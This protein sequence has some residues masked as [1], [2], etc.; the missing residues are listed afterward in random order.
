M[1]N[2]LINS[3]LTE[4]KSTLF[5]KSECRYGT[6]RKGIFLVSLFV[7][8]KLI[9]KLDEY[10]INNLIGK[11]MKKSD[12]LFELI[13]NMSMSEKRYFKLF[14]ARTHSEKTLNY[15]VLFDILDRL[16]NYE[17]SKVIRFLKREKI[18]A[19]YLAADKNYLYRMILK[20]LR[21]FHAG[22]SA[23]LRVKEYLEYLEILYHKGLYH[24][25]NKLLQKAKKTAQTF[26]LY[27]LLIEILNW[28]RLFANLNS[29]RKVVTN[30]SIAINENLKL[31]KNINAYNELYHEM[32]LLRLELNKAR[33]QKKLELLEN[34]IQH[35]L[36]ASKEMALSNIAKI[37][38]YEIWASYYFITDQTH[39][40][41]ECN[42]QAM[43]I[44][45]SIP[46]FM[47]E[48]AGKYTGIFSRI[49][50]LQHKLYP[51]K[52]KESLQQFRKIPSQIKKGTLDIEVSVFVLSY[53]IEMNILISELDYEQAIIQSKVIE[54]GF[55]KYKDSI[56]A[57]YYLTAYY[58]FAYVY[59]C[60]DKLSEALSYVNKINN[61]MDESERPDVFSN[62]KILNLIIHYELGNY[63]LLRYL[64]K[65][66][67]EFLKRRDRLH[68][69]EEILLRFFQKIA[70]PL[71]N[72]ERVLFFQSLE[73]QLNKVWEDPLEK[74][75][76]RYFDLEAWIE[77]KIKNETIWNIQKASK[78][79]TE[80]E[81]MN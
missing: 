70:K 48:W 63:N 57:S 4:N 36:L 77:S 76:L 64:I 61:E 14:I 58:R 3:Y 46:N 29:N 39:K 67:R 75:A 55:K 65:S 71:T 45:K 26:E 11:L 20:S 30:C 1:C 53:S 15:V 35:P 40:E 62:A 33:N 44:M 18:S 21:S 41:Y 32:M 31:L 73:Q 56:H 8:G 78:M 22:K 2:F 13:E 42:S 68:Q 59:F 43:E 25:A 27:S 50:V 17:E 72:K 52:C 6:G 54:K 66:T 23:S 47:E 37:R 16:K 24:Q 38:F 12:K 81:K 28:E 80:Q 51:E 79:L 9:S 10:V 5:S 34:L 69:T 7:I 74:R 19:K 60:S 49:L